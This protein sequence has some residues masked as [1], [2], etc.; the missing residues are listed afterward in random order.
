MI[1]YQGKT[2]TVDFTL[3]EST[4]ISAVTPYY[5]FKFYSPVSHRSVYFTAPNISNNKVRYDR[6][7]ITLTGSTNDENLTGGTIYIQPNGRWN[8]EVYQMSG[9]T[10]LDLTG[11]TGPAIEIGWLKISGGTDQK[12]IT[13]EYSGG[14]GYYTYYQPQQF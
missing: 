9:E 5:L 14:S 6:F 13:K 7:E 3:S 10:N 1:L 12:Y 8:F 11:V 2:N 4:T